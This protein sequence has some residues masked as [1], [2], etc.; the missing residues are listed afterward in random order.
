MA[1]TRTRA[2]KVAAGRA[3]RPVAEKEQF[4]YEV[5]FGWPGMPT[6]TKL[7]EVGQAV[8]VGTQIKVDGNW[9]VVEKVG[10]RS[11]G[12]EDESGRSPRSSSATPRSERSRSTRCGSDTAL[13][14]GLTQSCPIGQVEGRAG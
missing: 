12:T 1:S 7:V 14:Q 13:R 10:P 8:S 9:W 5:T 3:P 11:A 2:S 6:Q 4:F